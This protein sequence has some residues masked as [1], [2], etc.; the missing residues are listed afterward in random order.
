MKPVARIAA[1]AA[2][3]LIAVSG[4]A[5]AARKS[6]ELLQYIPADT[7]YVMAFTKPLPDDL[8]DKIEPAVDE[9]LGAYRRMIEF[10]LADAKAKASEGLAAEDDDAPMSDEEFRRFEAVLTEFLDMLSVQGLRDAGIGRDAL[11]AIYGDGLLPVIRIALTDGERFD[12]LIARF[13]SRAEASLKVAELGDVSYQYAELED[14]VRLIIATMK[15]DAVIALVPTGYDEERLAETLGI[16][17]PRNSLARSK[18]LSK[19]AKEYDFTDHSLGFLD[20]QRIA[21]SFLGDPSGL[22][23]ELFALMDYDASQLDDTCRAEFGKLAGVARRVVF[24]YTEVGARHMEASMVVELRDDIAAGLATLPAAVPGLG[25][26][27]GGL[28]SFGFSLN[29]LALRSFF[30][31]RLDAMEKD[32]FECGALAELQASTAKGRAALAQPIPPVIYNFRG[33][34]ASVADV[35]GFDPQSKQPPES[36]DA[37][38]LLAIE[39][40][41]DIVNMGAL[42]NPQIAALNLL[43]DGEARKLEFPEL[44]ELAKQAFAALSN[45]GLSVSIGDGAEQ[46][47]EAML[48]ADVASTRP[49]VSVSMDAQRYYEFVAQAVMQAEQSEE[50][51]PAPLAVREAMRDVMLSSGSIYNR[52]STHVYLT[53]RGIEV[54]TRMTLLD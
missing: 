14:K 49:F 24:G 26:D 35:T 17:K 21:A 9:T 22:N 5:D 34:L 18:A 20:V 29:P 6:K 2:L 7:P 52:M 39:N 50:Q 12:G 4:T 8:L 51:E 32:P 33:M 19:M 47:A 46:E 53:S 27:P 10:M 23:T 13:E 28:I 25:V 11:F 38:I 1:A 36:I 15:D 3:S 31:Q 30:E 44:G 40:A 37:G 43:P 41:Q 16:R 45:S 54:A 42:M 48:E